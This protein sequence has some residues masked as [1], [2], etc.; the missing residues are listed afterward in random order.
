MKIEILKLLS[1]FLVVQILYWSTFHIPTNYWSVG[2]N[3]GLCIAVIKSLPVSSL[4][5][6]LGTSKSNHPLVQNLF[7]GMMYSIGGDFCL[8]FPN[9][10]LPGMAFFLAAQISFIKAFSFEPLK[11]KIGVV[12]SLVMALVVTLLILPNIEGLVLKFGVPIYSIA[13]GIMTWRALARIDNGIIDKLTGLGAML[14]L[15]SDG[16]I[17]INMFYYKIPKA[18]EISLSTY[19]GAHFLISLS[20]CKVIHGQKRVHNTL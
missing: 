14:F 20:A 1:P 5:L 17:G 10:F 6:Y 16:C 12:I 4:V 15:I 9:F 13:L 8:V 19:Y 11:P 7:W 2:D 3:P 18:Q